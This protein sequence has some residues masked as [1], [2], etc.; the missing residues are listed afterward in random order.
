M[1]TAKNKEILQKLYEEL[2]KGNSN[3]VN[4]IDIFQDESIINHLSGIMATDFEISEV[5]K[6]IDDIISNY[7]KDKLISKRNEIIKKLE[8]TEQL[9][10]DEIA[11]LEKELNDSIIKLAKMK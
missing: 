1:W 2:E 7:E 9:T 4:I 10:K 11:N 3:I 5:S 6:C 8:N